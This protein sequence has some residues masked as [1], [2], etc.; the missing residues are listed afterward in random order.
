MC[1]SADN[2]REERED[3]RGRVVAGTR[4]SDAG[5][6]SHFSNPKSP[7]ANKSANH[8]YY[9]SQ[10]NRRQAP[11][12]SQA[13][14]GVQQPGAGLDSSSFPPR[15]PPF[16]VGLPW[17]LSAPSAGEP[18]GRLESNRLERRAPCSQ[19][20]PRSSQLPTVSESPTLRAEVVNARSLFSQIEMTLKEIDVSAAN[21]SDPPP[22]GIR[23][24]PEP[25][26]MMPAVPAALRGLR[27]GHHDVS[28]AEGGESKKTFGL[29]CHHVVLKV[30][31][32][33]NED[34]TLRGAG[35][36][37]KNVQIL[38]TGAFD[39]LLD[40]IRLRIGRHGTMV[41]IHKADIEK[42]ER[43]L[44]SEDEDD[45]EE[46]NEGLAKV[47]TRLADANKAIED[48]EKI[49]NTVE[50]DW[51]PASQRVIGHIRRSPPVAFNVQPGGYTE[52]WAAIELDGAKF[53]NLKGNFIDLGA[54]LFY[55]II[56]FVV[57]ASSDAFVH[58]CQVRRLRATSS[59][60]RCTHVTTGD[61]LLPLRDMITEELMHAPDMLDRD[62][63]A[64]LLVIKNGSATGVTIGRATGIESFVRDEDTGDVSLQWAIYRDNYDNKPGVF[65][66]PGDSGTMVADGLGRMGGILNGGAGKTESSDVTY[67]TPMWWIWPR[68]KAEFPHANLYPTTIV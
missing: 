30:D 26:K 15:P 53:K 21:M 25:P 60:S 42:L 1:W 39:A 23:R 13:F 22:T 18:P 49:F 3:G 63:E 55:F 6:Y 36:R 47:R 5:V 28:F 8:F 12:L 34:Y 7:S 52:D 46:A 43:M 16:T 31:A 11:S 57:V 19:Y 2:W 37:R 65:S 17:T 32:D 44:E 27:E 40:S 68:V 9:A 54:F 14:G 62:N 66:A 10:C 35:A 64:C 50:K 38:G 56:F 61:R 48:L 33:N 51:D 59:R 67:A 29:T 24:S 41:E 45:V 20:P 58:T 4:G